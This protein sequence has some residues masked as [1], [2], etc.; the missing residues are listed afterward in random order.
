M[1]AARLA[2]G[3]ALLLRN[4][5]GRRNMT[6]WS[7][8]SGIPLSP[9]LA[10]ALETVIRTVNVLVSHARASRFSGLVVM[11]RHLYCQLSLRRVRGLPR[12]RFLPWMLRRLPAPNAVIHFDIAP[13]QALDRILLRGTDTETL[14]E[15]AALRDGYRSLPEFPGFVRID[16]GRS[17][18]DVLAALSAAI[19]AAAETST[20]TAA[21]SPLTAPPGQDRV[22][23]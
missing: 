23:A 11:D 3:R 8:R 21:A 20:G 6:Q 22:S 9:R 10:D 16:A 1:D 15:L 13:E 5:A 17:E 14:E 4:H 7:E 12:G 19:T 18:K 2:G